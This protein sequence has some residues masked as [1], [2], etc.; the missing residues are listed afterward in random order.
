VIGNDTPADKKEAV[1]EG[2]PQEGL[3]KMCGYWAMIPFFPL[4]PFLLV[5]I[6]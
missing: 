4:K 6:F 2:C 5:S 1:T 3:K